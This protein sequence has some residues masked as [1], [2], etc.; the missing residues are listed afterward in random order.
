[1]MADS[2]EAASRALKNITLETINELVETIINY[3]QIEEQ[4]NEADITFKDISIIKEVFKK[5]LQNIYHAR[6]E[7]PK[8]KVEA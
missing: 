8:E 3:Q 7:Y 5:K 4:F 6:I 1:M 2:V